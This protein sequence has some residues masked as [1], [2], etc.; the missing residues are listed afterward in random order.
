MLM[1]N[2]TG[3]QLAYTEAVRFFIGNSKKYFHRYNDMDDEE[4][5]NYFR[6]KQHRPRPGVMNRYLPKHY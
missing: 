3:R 6:P 5:L 2:Y 4:R 1:Q